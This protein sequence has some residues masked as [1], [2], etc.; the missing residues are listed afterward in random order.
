MST[1][2]ETKPGEDSEPSPDRQQELTETV[3][4]DHFEVPPVLSI[5]TD[6]AP[7]LVDWD[8]ALRPAAS[9]PQAKDEG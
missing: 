3:D 6:I 9:L 2:G 1:R 5:R 7:G 8:P 4:L